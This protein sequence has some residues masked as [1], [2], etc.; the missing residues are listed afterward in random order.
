M[1]YS[2]INTTVVQ[3]QKQK[4]FEEIMI[5]RKVREIIANNTNEL[6]FSAFK[7]IEFDGVDQVQIGFA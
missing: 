5:R 3:K 7:Q 1:R 4:P 2:Q 6:Q